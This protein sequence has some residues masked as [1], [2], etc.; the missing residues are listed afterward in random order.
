MITIFKA[1][2]RR[3]YLTASMYVRLKC[4]NLFLPEGEISCSGHKKAN[5]N[6]NLAVA[7]LNREFVVF[8]MEYIVE[9]HILIII[10]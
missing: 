5:V 1:G 10:T 8:S 6:I 2:I 9:S 4:S 7:P 3:N